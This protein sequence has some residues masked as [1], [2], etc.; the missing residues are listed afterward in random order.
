MRRARRR[1]RVALPDAKVWVDADATRIAQVVGNLLHNA[2]KFTRRGDEVMVVVARRH[3]R[4]DPRPRHRRRDRPGAAPAGLRAV[5]PGGQSLARTQ[6]G[7]GLGLALV[8]GIV[9]LHG[10]SVRAESAGTAPAPSSSCGSPL[11]RART[12]ADRRGPTARPTAR[13]ARARRGRQQGRGRVARRA[14]RDAGAHGRGRA[15]TARRH[16]EGARDPPDVV[17][18]DLGLPGMSG[19]E[20]ARGLRA[21]RGDAS[22]A[23]RGQRVR[24]A[25]GRGERDRGG[26]RRARREA[27]GPGQACRA[28]RWMPGRTP[29]FRPGGEGHSSRSRK[30]R[31]PPLAA[32]ALMG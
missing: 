32:D 12:G 31:S 8:K 13:P 23:R 14:R 21:A 22:P 7:L 6:G 19:Y 24:A 28:P 1:V 15:T 25:G 20:V 17:L 29:G 4:R 27:G 30:A 3:G 10:G 18:C 9:E 5:R 26:V 16:R 11:A 2:A